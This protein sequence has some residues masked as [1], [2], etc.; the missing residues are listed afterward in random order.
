MPKL[1]I[2]TVNLNN[3][4]GFI[5]TAESVVAQAWDDYEWIIIDGGSTDGSADVIREYVGKFAKIT[6]WCSEKD[7]GVYFGMNKG[8]ARARGEYCYFLNSGDYLC[9]SSSLNKIFEVDFDEDIVYG[10]MMLEKENGKRVIRKFGNTIRPPDLQYGILPHQNMLIKT[11]L[12]LSTNGYK[13]DYRIVS[14]WEYYTTAICKNKASYRHIPVVLAINQ[15]GGMSNDA[16]FWYIQKAER[17]IVIKKLFPVWLRVF[18]FFSMA[19]LR[20]KIDKV[21]YRLEKVLR[22]RRMK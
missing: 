13:T 21:G 5:K 10:D 2:I 1:S 9:E 22:N 15:D 11:N 6:F 17:K 7:G 18:Y 4:V 16:R 12:L 8:I 20:S 19:S 3:N 14:D